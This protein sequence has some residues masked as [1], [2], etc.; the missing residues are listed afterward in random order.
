MSVNSLFVWYFTVLISGDENCSTL[1]TGVV[2]GAERYAGDQITFCIGSDRLRNF[3]LDAFTHLDER[4]DIGGRSAHGA[5]EFLGVAASLYLLTRGRS[6]KAS[7]LDWLSCALVLL[8][9][10]LGFTG[11]SITFFALYLLIRDRGDLNT[12]A[13]GTVA[14]AVVVQAVWAP[15]IF[16][17]ISFLLLQGDASIVGWLLGFVLP[18]ASWGGTVVYTPSGHNVVITEPCASFHNLS[19]AT[20]CWVTLTMLHRP[21]WLK[22][23]LYVGLVAILIQFG[24][25]VWRFVFVC[26][27]LPM[28]EFWHNGLGKH[29][30]SAIATACAII[31]V[32]FWLVRRDQRDSQR[33]AA[34]S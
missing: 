25:N 2:F 15:L 7:L 18:G 30:F 11:S 10:C 12:K 32:Q 8:V 16:S 29:V 33:V 23:D 6:G 4:V 21:Y 1:I 20:L 31:V 5:F 14:A 26:L 34:I 13:A 27:S 28:Y 19:L 22:S 17:K 3:F 24:F 9:A